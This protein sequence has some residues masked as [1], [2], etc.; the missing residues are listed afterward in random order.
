ML[1]YALCFVKL[2]STNER[3]TLN[4]F[5]RFPKMPALTLIQSWGPLIMTNEQVFLRI[6]A[7]LDAHRQSH[8]LGFWDSLDPEKQQHLLA[9]I[10]ELDFDH[11][12]QRVQDYVIH[13]RSAKMPTEFTPAPAY[14]EDPV[15]APMT[16]KYAEATALGEKLLQAGQI[17]AFVVAGGQGTR[18]GF[19]GPKGNYPISPSS[20]RPSLRALQ[21]RFLPHHRNTTHAAPCTS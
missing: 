15:D 9:Q 8:L 14:P 21:S 20:R 11:I 19:E 2:I 16:Q 10:E 12:D 18:L 4:Y 13:D 17:G 3:T 6:Q 5:C 7:Q 1:V